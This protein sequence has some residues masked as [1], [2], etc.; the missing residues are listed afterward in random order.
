[1]YGP[2]LFRIALFGTCLIISRRLSIS[3]DDAIE[4]RI[5]KNF[6]GGVNSP[7]TPN[8]NGKIIEIIMKGAI[9]MKIYLDFKIS[10]SVITKPP[11]RVSPTYVFSDLIKLGMKI[12]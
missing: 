11:K 7:N 5:I 8:I 6:S 1:V 3:T 10:S 9:V 2:L 12:K 4:F